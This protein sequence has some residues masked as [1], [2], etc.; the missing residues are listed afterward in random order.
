MGEVQRR[1]WREPLEAVS[2][3]LDQDSGAQALAEP[4]ALEGLLA[5]GRELGY[6]T[7]EQI[8][9][10]LEEVEVT[11][12]QVSACTPTWSSTASK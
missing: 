12:E 10:T 1:D 6:L 11:K 8:A 3:G 5:L 2:Q 9:S 4:E 7:F